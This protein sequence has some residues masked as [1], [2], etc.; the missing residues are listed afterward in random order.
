MNGIA[1]GT[2]SGP[3]TTQKP[4]TITTQPPVQQPPSK[5]SNATMN[6]K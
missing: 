2:S 1:N 5:I 4:S 6:A 3:N